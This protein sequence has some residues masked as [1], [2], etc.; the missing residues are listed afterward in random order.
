MFTL[1]MKDPDIYKALLLPGPETRIDRVSV[2]TQVEFVASGLLL[3]LLLCIYLPFQPNAE[4]PAITE[5]D[6]PASTIADGQFPVK[7]P[8]I[9]LYLVKLSQLFE[10]R[11]CET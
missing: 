8:F 2:G 7:N 6:Y 1:V 10:F 11:M 9:C 5:T 3:T 4:A